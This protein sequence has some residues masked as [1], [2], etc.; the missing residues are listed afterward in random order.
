MVIAY[1][2][3]IAF[4]TRGVRRRRCRRR[5]GGGGGG[6]AGSPSSE[7]NSRTLTCCRKNRMCE[8]RPAINNAAAANISGAARW[9]NAA[10]PLGAADV[11]TEASARWSCLRTRRGRPR[12]LPPPIPLIQWKSRKTCW[13]IKGLSRK[14]RGFLH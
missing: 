3:L 10:G 5:R 11:V 9:R 12:E 1:F 13:I 2:P 6:G 14:N 8:R 7:P 4:V